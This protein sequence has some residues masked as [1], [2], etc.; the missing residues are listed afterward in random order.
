MSKFVFK[1]RVVQSYTVHIDFKSD[2]V[3]VLRKDGTHVATCKSVDEAWQ[4][5][6]AD[7]QMR[8]V[9]ARM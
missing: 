3:R 1:P 4:A 8:L 7:A 5:A 6:E 9:L 2:D